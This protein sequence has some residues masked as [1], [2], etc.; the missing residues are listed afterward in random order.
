MDSEVNLLIK[1]WTLHNA[2]NFGGNANPGAIIGKL[3]AEKPE[4]KKQLKELQPLIQ[5]TV[6]EV[7]SM[8]NDEQFAELKKIAPELLE[9]KPKEKREGLR[10][11][12][13]AE[14]GKIVVRVEPSPS[15][16]L[17]IGHAYAIGINY[18]YKKMYDG[19]LY[20]RISDT[21][22][23]NIY[24]PAYEL[25]EKDANWLTEKG[26]TDFVIQSD[27][28]EK[29][30]K[31]AEKLI[32][33][34]TAYVCTCNPD[35][36]HS[37]INKKQACP[38]RDISQK[39]NL[40]RWAKMFSDFSPGEA[41]V[42][43][44]TDV[45]HSNPAMRD[46]PALRINDHVH[47]RTKD[48]F[49][50]WP[51]MN[52]AVAVDDHDLGMTHVINGKD[53]A[54]NAKRQKYIFDYM[55]WKRPQYINWGRINFQGFEVSCTKTKERI[56][57]GEFDGWDD[58]RLPFLP[59]LRRRGYQP[60]AFVKLAIDIGLSLTDK[61]VSMEEFFKNLNANNKD[62][63]DPS[64][65]RFFFI[66]DPVEIEIAGIPERDLELKKHPDF[67]KRG[68]RKFHTKNRFYIQREDWAS[69][70]NNEMYRLM[71]CANFIRRNKAYVFDSIEYEKYK[72]F[73]DFIMHWLPV[74][75]DLV[76][77]EV[78]MPDKTVRKGLGE[79]ELKHINKG[80]IVQLERF[81]FCRLDK[82]EGNKLTFW[83]AHR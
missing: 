24:A 38:C 40:L 2:V 21:N 10:P 35:E 78:L 58:I 66:D 57:Q 4:L 76:N 27:R 72:T 1:K 71:D 13:D 73:G 42:R 37:L 32:S 52:L 63:I 50:V 11:L 79:P 51:L 43:I 30:Y 47:P 16:P 54:D 36:F 34:C 19:K 53:H 23:E 74:S 80:D 20:V 59:A 25:I 48:K 77:V 9:E 28:L 7:N 45:E 5:K 49:R 70:K 68:K 44:K 56:Q 26:V 6:H 55:G 69:I 17:H 14:K 8:A 64:S 33:D 75:D 65:S 62:I 81:G 3:I 60:G 41:V 15:G 83:F 22:P 61:T 31:V 18:G 12:V 46:W 29:Y 39:E 67:P 82:I